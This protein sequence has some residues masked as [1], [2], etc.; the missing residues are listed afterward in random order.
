ML[1]REF[2]AGLGSAAVWPVVARAQQAAMP[3]VGFLNGA[4]A[5]EYTRFVE[6]FRHGLAETGYAEGR[7]V[8]I[9]YRWAEGHYERLPTL[10]A[11]LVRRRVAVIVASGPSVLP[12]KEATTAIPIVFQAAGTRSRLDWLSA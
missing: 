7:N 9:D 1:R 6:A 8:F 2:I 11:D 10:A 3:V 5:W 4:S 12:A